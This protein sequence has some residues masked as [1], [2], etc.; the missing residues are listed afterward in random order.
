M[1]V[2]DDFYD[3][4]KINITIKNKLL[5]LLEKHK[6]RQKMYKLNDFLSGGESVILFLYGVRP[7][8]LF[9]NVL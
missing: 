5:N 8:L 7:Y 2:Y 4:L 6:Y 1:Y 9:R 3:N